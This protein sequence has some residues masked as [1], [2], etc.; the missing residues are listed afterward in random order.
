M[1]NRPFVSLLVFGLA[2]FFGL[3]ADAQVITLNNPSFE[4]QAG[5]GVTPPGWLDCGFPGETPPDT[6]P[7]GAFQVYKSAHDGYTYLGMVTR[8]NDTWEAV[9]QP[10]S[11]PLVEGRC[12]NFSLYISRS[13]TYVSASN[14]SKTI[15]NYTDPIV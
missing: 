4:G 15:D 10:L 12:Y 9:G 7:S 11:S 3:P 6:H 8:G 13:E 14:W 2:I 1:N 5:G